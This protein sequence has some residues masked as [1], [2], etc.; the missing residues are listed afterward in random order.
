[1]KFS[2]VLR[3]VGLGLVLVGTALPFG[4]LRAETIGCTAI[5]TLPATITVQ[6]IYCLTGDLGTSI[7]SGNAITIA[8]NNV[9][10]DL[11]GHKIGGLAAGPGTQANGIY[12]LDRTN[13][14]LRNGTIRGFYYGVYVMDD[15]TYHDGSGGHVI[16]N[17]RADYNTYAGLFVSGIGNIIRSNQ[18]VNTGGS[19]VFSGAA[20]RGIMVWG[21]GARVLNNDVIGTTAQGVGY[22]AF[23]IDVWSGGGSVVEN[24]RVAETISPAG[25]AWAIS[26]GTSDSSAVSGNRIGNSTV[27]GGSY[28]IFFQGSDFVTARDNSI[29]KMGFGIDFSSATGVYMNNVVL[30]AVSGQSYTGG[31]AAGTNYP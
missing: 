26:V 24:N 12:A 21:R 8:T 7:L 19:T 9:T 28:G 14:N 22:Q 4:Y 30:G 13:I 6:G 25:P 2:R 10:I 16:E 31:T 18:V 11:N 20:A 23:G 17:L 27:S 3:F 5:T 15:S 29:S 1:M